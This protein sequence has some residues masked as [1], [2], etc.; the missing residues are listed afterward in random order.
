MIYKQLDKIT[1]SDLQTLLDNAVC[2]SKTIEYKSELKIDTGDDRKEFLAD[3]TSFANADGGDILFGIKEDSSSNLP[4]EISGIEIGT[5]DE[6]IRKIESMLRDSV[7]PR[8]PDVS[9]NLLE[10]CAGRYVLIMRIAASLVSPHRVTYKGYDKFFSRNAKGKYPMDVNELRTAFTMSHTLIK[11]IERYK[12][13]RIRIITE[14]KYKDL[15]EKMPILI[16]LALPLNAFRNNSL[17]SMKDIIKTMQDVGSTA[18][19]YHLNTQVTIDGIKLSD[20]NSHFAMAHYKT[21]GIVEKVATDIFFPDYTTRSTPSVTYSV[22]SSQD[23]IKKL[24]EVIDELKQY[25]EKLNI[26]PPILLSCAIV[27][28]ANFSFPKNMLSLLRDKSVIDR[29]LVM[30]P[31]VILEDFSM[32]TTAILRPILNSLWNA[33]GYIS[34]PAY[35]E[36]GEYVGIDTN[37]HYF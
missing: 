27:N 3:V 36:T 31:D 7:A 16:F 2:E 17:Y 26:T 10:I 30:V 9:F 1:V 19:G 11:E 25:Y 15:Q 32:E 5:E 24:F 21:N 13:E 12:D 18:F 29:D 8:I 33:C 22:I 6:L 20:T 35:S 37:R 4:C 14:N 28:A 34:C 23:L